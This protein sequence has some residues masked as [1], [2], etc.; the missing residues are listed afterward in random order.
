V[1]NARDT[2]ENHRE[3]ANPA[4]SALVIIDHDFCSPSGAMAQRFGF[5]MKEIKAAVRRLNAFIETC[6]KAGVFVVW[7]GETFSDNK[8]RPNQKALW[9]GGDHIWLIRAGGK[10]TDWYEGMIQPR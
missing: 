9:G 10:G 8:M 3:V 6:R 1:P 4:H 7:V 5:D 2:A